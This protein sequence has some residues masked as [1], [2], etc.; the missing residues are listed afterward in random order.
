MSNNPFVY[1]V[2]WGDDLLSQFQTIAFENELSTFAHAPQWQKGLLDVTTVLHKCS[3]YALNLVSKSE[4]PSALLLFLSA[5][6]L[7]LASIRSVSAGHCLAVYPTGRATIESALYGWYLSTDSEAALRWNNKPTNKGSLRTW[8]NEFKF[9]SLAKKLGTIDGGLVEW[10]KYLHQG[11]IDFGAHP[12]KDALYT[13]IE[14]KQGENGEVLLRML[15]LHPWNNFSIGATKFTIETG[16]FVFRLFGLG[17]PDAERL[18]NLT[19]D[20]SRLKKS[21]ADLQKTI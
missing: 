12:N 10:A 20:F 16:M 21:L 6:N 17:F 7:Y 13:N 15:F 2:G 3:S 4:E 1:P 9:S 8:G 18:L 19:Q 5:H 14:K 11:A